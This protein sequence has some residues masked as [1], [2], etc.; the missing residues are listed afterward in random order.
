MKAN[1]FIMEFTVIDAVYDY[2]FPGDIYMYKKPVGKDPGYYLKRHNEKSKSLFFLMQRPHNYRATK[3]KQNE[4]T[5]LIELIL[6][7]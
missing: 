6:A 2:E 7:E 4:E 3:F 1:V 5:I